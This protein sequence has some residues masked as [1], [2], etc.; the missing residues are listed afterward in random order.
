[1]LNCQNKVK[2]FTFV[3]KNNIRK[4]E[5]QNIALFL[6]KRKPT[7]IKFNKRVI[8]EDYHTVP[9]VMCII[10]VHDVIKPLV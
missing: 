3:A 2:P 10:L 4:L 7:T 6:P 1:M 8:K 5:I 9:Y